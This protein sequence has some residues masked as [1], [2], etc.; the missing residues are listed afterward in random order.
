M[1]FFEVSC[2]GQ[3]TFYA[4][5]VLAKFGVLYKLGKSR[6]DPIKGGPPMREHCT[7]GPDKFCQNIMNSAPNFNTK[8][9]DDKLSIVLNVNFSS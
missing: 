1:H 6:S 5:M 3:T 7:G 9:V 2:G 4:K 8:T